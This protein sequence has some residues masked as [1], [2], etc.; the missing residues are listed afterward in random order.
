METLCSLN[1]ELEKK[2]LEADN[3]LKAAIE[4]IWDLRE[5][6][7]DLEQ[8]LQVKN[9]KYDALQIQVSELEESILFQTQKQKD[10]V[11]ELEN[12]KTGVENNQLTEQIESLQVNSINSCTQIIFSYVRFIEP[13]F[14]R[15]NYVNNKYVQSSLQ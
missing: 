6:V 4:K 3:E 12:L 8:Q 1:K 9:E 15:M 11:Q 5:V 7:S 14:L 10:L 13:F 2:K